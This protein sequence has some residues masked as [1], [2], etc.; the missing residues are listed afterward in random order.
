M[1]NPD[2]TGDLL[3]TAAAGATATATATATAALPPAK[4]PEALLASPRMPD[5]IMGILLTDEE[6]QGAIWWLPN[7]DSFIIHKEK[8]EKEI[9]LKYFRGNK[10]KSMVRNLHRW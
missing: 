10:F 6:A 9:L 1:M 7:G 8:F 2:K 3:G 4:L 5:K